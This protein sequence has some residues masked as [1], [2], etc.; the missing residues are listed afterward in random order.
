MNS[1]YSAIGGGYTNTIAAYSW[2]STIPGGGYNTIGTNSPCITIGGG[3]MNNIGD[4]SYYATI[5]AGAGNAIG[6]NSP[7]GAI[8]GGTQ[9]TIATDSSVAT[10]G[11][12][13]WNAIGT[14][15]PHGA[16][17]GGILNTIADTSY[18]A[19]IAGG[20]NNTIGTNSFFSAIGGGDN[21]TV[22]SDAS[23]ATIPGGHSNK[24]SGPF[25]FAAGNRAK[26]NHT[27]A[28]V[29]GDSTEADFASTG[30][31]QFLI[32]ASGGVGIGTVS[33]TAA[34]E[35]AGTVKATGFTG[36]GAGLTSL[37]ANNLSS[38]TVPEARIDAAI[39]RDS[40]IMPAVLA[41]DGPGSGLDADLLD[42]QHAAAFVLSGH[43]H[44]TSYWKL[45]GNAGTSPGTH[46]IGTT[47]NR[48]LE[49][50]VNNQRALR[51]ES[52]LGGSSVSI[53]GGYAGNSVRYGAYGATV[54]GGGAG[55]YLGYTYTNVVYAHFGTVG[56]SNT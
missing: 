44:D 16:I 1:G 3:G 37:N 17:G 31:N 12:G 55:N 46:F 18:S 34:L 51:L 33:P 23:Y 43:N 9:N 35:V 22:A 8:G 7:Y 6:T 42:G 10:I 13:Q 24:V 2:E 56:G 40:E 38:G 26:A 29:W 19:T 5:A 30:N 32:R 25:G 48:A 52:I 39:A 14:N 20:G 50:K 53:V 36:D 45:G 47:D 49:L 15:S 27:G 54:G 41:N 11:G 4:N 28:F 21:N